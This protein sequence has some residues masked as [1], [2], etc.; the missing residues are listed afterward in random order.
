MTSPET[1]L[2]DYS[3]K[4]M[5]YK[6]PSP[7]RI[8]LLGENISGQGYIEFNR[9]FCETQWPWPPLFS[10]SW[11]IQWSIEERI[12]YNLVFSEWRHYSKMWMSLLGAITMV[13]TGQCFFL[14]LGLHCRR[15]T[16]EQHRATSY[17]RWIFSTKCGSN[18]RKTAAGASIIP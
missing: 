15:W 18:M 8:R 2:N 10:L 5:L 4:L 16:T 13:A 1:L 14:S 3:V 17:I 9:I 6:S 11:L 7:I 12:F